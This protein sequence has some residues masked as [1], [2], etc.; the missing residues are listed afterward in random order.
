MRH[1][2]D[3]TGLVLTKVEIHLV[4]SPQGL[5]IHRSFIPREAMGRRRI[6]T[7]IVTSLE[8]KNILIVMDRKILDFCNSLVEK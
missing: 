4:L 1:S 5:G 6:I 2:Q 8:E 3:M 7:S